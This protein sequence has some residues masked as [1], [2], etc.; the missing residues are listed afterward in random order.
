MYNNPESYRPRR[1]RAFVG[2]VFVDQGWLKTRPGKS[3]DAIGTV[4]EIIRAGMVKTSI[5]KVGD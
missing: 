2:R 3:T 5:I 1:G 4:C